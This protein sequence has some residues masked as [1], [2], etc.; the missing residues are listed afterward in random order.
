M[1]LTIEEITELEK[2]LKKRREY[3][4]DRWWRKQNNYRDRM[5]RFVYN[6]RNRNDCI[7][8]IKNAYES[9]NINDKHRFF[10]YSA[11]RRYN[12]RSAQWVENLFKLHPNVIGEENETHQY[13]DFYIDWIPFD[14]KTTI[15]PKAYKNTIEYAKEN[16]GD[17][18]DRLYKNQSTQQRFHMKNRLF[19][20]MHSL[21]W[22]DWKLKAELSF[23]KPIIDEYLN[24]FRKD[25]LYK[26][27]YNYEEIFSDTIRVEK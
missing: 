1:I 13:I 27:K 16:K 8:G 12:F 15:F 3:H 22:D 24:N 14:H 10:N 18:I 19:V 17:L 26:F 23:M 21:N 7:K 6:I 9:N 4:Y 20:V 11:N 25:R 5:T 2:E